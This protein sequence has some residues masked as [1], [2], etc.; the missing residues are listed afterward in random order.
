M[1]SAKQNFSDEDLPYH[2][3]AV[4]GLLSINHVLDS[5]QEKYVKKVCAACSKSPLLV[6]LVKQLMNVSQTK[7]LV[8][9]QMM[10][11]AWK[12]AVGK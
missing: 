5:K 2:M 8:D 1:K 7:N 3:K 11:G 9:K 6:D 4:T 12:F 10:L